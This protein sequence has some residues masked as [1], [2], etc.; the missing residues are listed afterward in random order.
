MIRKPHSAAANGARRNAEGNL[1]VGGYG[2]T[3]NSGPLTP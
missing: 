1:R 3:A 2:Q